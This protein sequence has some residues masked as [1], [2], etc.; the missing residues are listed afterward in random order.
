MVF[1]KMM[2]LRVFDTKLGA[3]GME[4]ICELQHCLSPLVF[5]CGPSH[6]LVVIVANKLIL[7]LDCFQKKS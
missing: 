6:V 7:F 3:Q 1:Q 5:Q 2:S 4:D